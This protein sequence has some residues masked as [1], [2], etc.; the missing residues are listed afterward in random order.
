MV[1]RKGEAF[2]Q[3]KQ[4]AP[5]VPNHV[6]SCYLTTGC[7][8]EFV[9]ALVRWRAHI[10]DMLTM[11]L[12]LLLCAWTALFWVGPGFNPRYGWPISIGICIMAAVT[13]HFAAP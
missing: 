7:C 11:A 12:K 9:S 1:F 10:D 4:G 13:L 5:F 2:Q 8:F 3:A 6:L